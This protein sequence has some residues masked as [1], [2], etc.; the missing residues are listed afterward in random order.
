MNNE[1]AKF[2]MWCGNALSMRYINNDPENGPAQMRC[3]NSQHSNLED[4]QQIAQ[5]QMIRRPATE[6][7][8]ELVY[9][10]KEQL[11][12]TPNYTLTHDNLDKHI[13]EL[14]VLAHRMKPLADAVEELDNA[15]WLEMAD[16]YEDEVPTEEV[17]F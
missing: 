12:Q 2:C 6:I 14:C 17:T 5:W 9:E 1:T 11:H 8:F 10:L 3:S 4:E 13:D 15:F 16:D 7:M